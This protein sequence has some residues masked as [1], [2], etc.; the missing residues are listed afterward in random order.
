MTDVVAL[1]QPEPE[2]KPA[3]PDV[4]IDWLMQ[5]VLKNRFLPSPDPNS[6]FVGDGDYRAVGAEFLGHFIRRAAFGPTRACSTSVPAS[7]AWQCR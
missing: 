4:Q 1:K 5:S 2:A 6:V 3:I 7:V